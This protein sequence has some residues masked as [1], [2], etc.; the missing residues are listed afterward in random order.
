[1][2]KSERS[3]GTRLPLGRREDVDIRH[4]RRLRRQSSHSLGTQQGG[5]SWLLRG[6][7]RYVALEGPA[8][9]LLDHSISVPEGQPGTT[10]AA[11]AAILRFA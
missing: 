10:R 4:A 9:R 3:S 5:M 6:T 1:M 2:Y 11:T 8:V 7:D